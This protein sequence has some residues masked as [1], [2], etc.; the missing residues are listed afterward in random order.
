LTRYPSKSVT[1][2]S[3]HVAKYNF[4]SRVGVVDLSIAAIGDC[5]Y[6]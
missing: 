6:P 5:P 2:E 3:Y 1:F 4:T